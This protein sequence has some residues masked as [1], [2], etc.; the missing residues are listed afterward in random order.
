MK[1]VFE[2]EVSIVWAGKDG[3]TEKKSYTVLA[4]KAEEALTKAKKKGF[5][6]AYYWNDDEDGNK[7]K[8]MGVKD[9][10]I[11]KVEMTATIDVA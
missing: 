9:V 10:L 7:K 11:E 1:K 2:V 8:Y 6:E 5:S 4:N 3:F